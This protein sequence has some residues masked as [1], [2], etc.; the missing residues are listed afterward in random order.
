MSVRKVFS[1][2]YKGEVDNLEGRH[3]KEDVRVEI[4]EYME[5]YYTR[6]SAYN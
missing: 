5:M 2:R 6:A 1:R 4:F 3:T